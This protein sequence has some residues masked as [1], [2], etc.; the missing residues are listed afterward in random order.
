MSTNDDE[1]SHFLNL[2]FD[3]FRVNSQNSYYNLRDRPIIR[4]LIIL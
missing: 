4:V 1:R 2:L 3:K